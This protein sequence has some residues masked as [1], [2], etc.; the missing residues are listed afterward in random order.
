MTVEFSQIPLDLEYPRRRAF[1]RGDFVISDAN[2]DAVAMLDA[3]QSWPEGRLCLVGDRGAGKTH[4]AT[5]WVQEVGAELYDADALADLDAVEIAEHPC[6]VIENASAIAG[7]SEQEQALFHLLNLM[8]ERGG[9]VLLTGCQTPVAWGIVLPDLRSRLMA[10]GCAVAHPPDDDLLA[11]VIEKL[12][13]DRHIAVDARVPGFLA[14]R[15]ERSFQAAQAAVD[16]LEAVSLADPKNI[17]LKKA[18]HVCKI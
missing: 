6:V 8:K 2:A 5:V 1:G 11:A 4:L 10:S 9:K 18:K 17:T 7:K 3:W 12:L 15:I 14:R 16:A 13:R